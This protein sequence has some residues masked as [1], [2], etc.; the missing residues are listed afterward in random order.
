MSEPFRIMDLKSAIARHRFP[1]PNSEKPAWRTYINDGD[2]PIA[3]L[4]TIDGEVYPDIL[5]IDRAT[6]TNKYIMAAAICLSEPSAEDLV[7]WRRIA[8]AADA[9]Y[10][11]VPADHC[12]RAAELA[13]TG[14][15]AV[16]GFRAFTHTA[17]AVEITDCS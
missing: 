6:A 16:T 3:A 15:L 1:F 12:R 5:V 7:E 13:A 17:G 11:F 2:S 9:L 10:V 8:A 4:P 14:N